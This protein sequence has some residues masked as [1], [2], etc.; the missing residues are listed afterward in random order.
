[1]DCP[2]AKNFEKIGISY[3]ATCDGYLTKNKKVVVVGNNEEAISTSIFIASLAK[4]VTLVYLGKIENKDVLNNSKNTITIKENV[5]INNVYGSSFK[6][7]GITL[8]NEKGSE[9]INCDFIFVNLGVTP[10]VSF[11]SEF[12]EIINSEG[13][14]ETNENK[15]TKI[16]GI[17]AVG[18]VSKTLNRQIIT[19]ANDGAIAGISVVEYL[20]LFKK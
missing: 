4:Q 11:L 7:E 2:N 20:N 19:A 17:Y 6:L 13:I 18:D 10:A 3:C 16:N 5:K 1:L 8:I 12:K 15:Q 9:K 14:I